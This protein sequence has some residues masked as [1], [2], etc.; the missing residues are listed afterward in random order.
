MFFPK[1]ALLRDPASY[2]DW[3][4]RRIFKPSLPGGDPRLGGHRIS[5]EPGA[6]TKP[7]GPLGR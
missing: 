4:R 7:P 1:H 5:F 3:R 2:N 6:P